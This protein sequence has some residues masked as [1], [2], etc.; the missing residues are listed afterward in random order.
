MGGVLILKAAEK[1]HLL[2][3]I[4]SSCNLSRIIIMVNNMDKNLII[5]ITCLLM[6]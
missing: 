1:R 6:T 4:K 3:E 5:P 2:I